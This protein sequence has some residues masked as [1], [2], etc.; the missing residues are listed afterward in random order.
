MLW[1]PINF[2]TLWIVFTTNSIFTI[3]FV[4]KS[5]VW[6]I[7]NTSVIRGMIVARIFYVEVK[8]F[9][10][11]TVNTKVYA[12]LLSMF[13]VWKQFDFHLI[14]Y[15][16]CVQCI[17]LCVNPFLCVIQAYLQIMHSMQIWFV[18]KVGQISFRW[19]HSDGV[20]SSI[21]NCPIWAL[22]LSLSEANLVH[23]RPR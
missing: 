4:L 12:H 19:S 20:W 9:V 6:F 11:S 22:S 23:L 21:W 17:I 10:K 13:G 3:D 18:T 8:K 7:F 14:L 5:L 2:N 1:T 16:I 15:L